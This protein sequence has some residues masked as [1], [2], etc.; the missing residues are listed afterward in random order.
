MIPY[1]DCVEIKDKN[2]IEYKRIPEWHNCDYIKNRN[3]LIK[4]AELF[5]EENSSDPYQFTKVF[6]TKMDSLAKEYG[7]VK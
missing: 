5:A 1:C 4:V 6:S 2:G 3:K 7:L